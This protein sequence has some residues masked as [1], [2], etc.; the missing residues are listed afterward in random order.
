MGVAAGAAIA[1][2]GAVL[3]HL[4][5][6][7]MG[8]ETA[9]RL[10]A[11]LAFLLFWPSYVGGALVALFG[12][13]FQLVKRRA[14]ELGLAFASVLT[15]HLGLIASLCWIGSAPPV[16][17]F[18]IFG[19]GVFWTYLLALFSIERFG[20]VLGSMGWWILRNIGS[21]YI[22]YAFALDFLSPLH[23]GTVRHPVEYVPFAVLAVLGPALRLIA[24]LKLSAQSTY[25][26]VIL[27]R[28]LNPGA[29]CARLEK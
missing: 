9:L 10:T 21:N 11:R 20:R 17:I 15:V 26:K 19:I 5:V 4:G 3:G 18:V 12:P 13:R 1:L 7:K 28:V 14:R 29:K 6:G 24:A 16:R 8:I 2:T 27:N 25:G 23:R 22:A